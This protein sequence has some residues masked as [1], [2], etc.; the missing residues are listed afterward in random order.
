MCCLFIFAFVTVIK[1]FTYFYAC[2]ILYMYICK[3]VHIYIY[4]VKMNSFELV[5]FSFLL[6]WWT[7]TIMFETVIVAIEMRKSKIY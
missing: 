1:I 3:Y 5:S 7:I 6:F 4:V 2:N